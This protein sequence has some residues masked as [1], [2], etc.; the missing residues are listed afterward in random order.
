MGFRCNIVYFFFSSSY[1]WHAGTTPILE[2]NARRMHGQ[3]DI[4]HVGSHQFRESLRELLREL[5]FS[6]CSSRRMPFREWNFVFREW[7]IEFRELLREYPRTLRKFREWPCHSKSVFLKSGWSPGFWILMP[8]RKAFALRLAAQ[9]GRP[10]CYDQNPIDPSKPSKVTVL[11]KSLHA[12]NY[13]FRMIEG[14]TVTA[15]R[16][17]SNSNEFA[18]QFQFPC[19]FRR[20]HLQKIISHGNF[21]SLLQLQLHDLM[22]SESTVGTKIIADPEKCFQEL[23]SE[24]LLIFFAG[25]ALFGI[26][27]RFQ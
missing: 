18:L 4:F 25:W 21:N 26:N 9:A 19:P 2:K 8:A 11:L 15:F 6:Y 7:N 16:G 5:W 1:F 13:Y 17:L 10:A 22:V 12:W 27:Y 23:L 24:K 3:M 20:M 14:I